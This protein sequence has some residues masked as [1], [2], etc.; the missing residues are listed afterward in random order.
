MKRIHGL[1][2]A[3]ALMIALAACAGDG[4]V[5]VGD[6]D[7]GGQRQVELGREFTMTV[8][9]TVVVEDSNLVVFF[10]R[11]EGDS[12]CPT[13][14]TCVWEGNAAVRLQLSSTIAEFAPQA[15]VLNTSLEPHAVDFLGV[16]VRLVDVAPY[17][18]AA[19]APIE[20]SSY[21]VKLVVTRP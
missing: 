9:E 5:G 10:E 16:T 20:P 8:G 1:S 15:R 12:R 14:V 2:A 4:S 11:V 3:S 13:G 18:S 7:V 19:G 21:V 17:P 6:Q